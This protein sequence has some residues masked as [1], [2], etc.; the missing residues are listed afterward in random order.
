M[1]TRPLPPPCAVLFVTNVK[2]LARF[3][4]ELAA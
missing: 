1:N 3:Y 4:R 2:R